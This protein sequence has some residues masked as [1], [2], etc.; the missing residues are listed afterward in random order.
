MHVQAFTDCDLILQTGIE[1]NA[2]CGGDRPEVDVEE[3]LDV[4]FSCD[5]GKVDLC[6]AVGWKERS[7]SGESGDVDQKP[8][9]R[10]VRERAEEAA[11]KVQSVCELYHTGADKAN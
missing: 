7:G 9:V 5:C 1:E 10:W 6:V 8:V 11:M 4:V 2:L 3:S